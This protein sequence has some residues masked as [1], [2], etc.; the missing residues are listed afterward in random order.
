MRDM[1]N[2]EAEA[3]FLLIVAYAWQSNPMFRVRMVQD[4]LNS[5][6]ETGVPEDVKEVIERLVDNGLLSKVDGDDLWIDDSAEE[7]LH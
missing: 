6:Y 3:S 1:T 2:E 7:V 4:A 5:A